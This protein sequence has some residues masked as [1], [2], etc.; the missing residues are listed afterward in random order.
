MKKF[1]EIRNCI[2]KILTNKGGYDNL[3][4]ELEEVTTIE[5]IDTVILK[6][7]DSDI[8]RKILLCHNNYRPE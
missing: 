7:K 5:E 8:Y 2:I 4:T 6:V 3:I 1:D